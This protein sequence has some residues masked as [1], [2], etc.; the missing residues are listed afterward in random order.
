MT[1]KKVNESPMHPTTPSKGARGFKTGT[2]H[3]APLGLSQP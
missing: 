3:W 2:V 1:F